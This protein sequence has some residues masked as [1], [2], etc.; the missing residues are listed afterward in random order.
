MG[1]SN[2]RIVLKSPLYGG[3][4]G[5]VC[6]AMANMGICDLAIAEPRPL[7][8]DEA[9][10]MACHARDILDRRTEFASLA[11]AVA[12]CGLVMVTTA[13]LGLYRQHARTPRGWADKALEGSIEGK[14][15]IVFGPEDNGLT[16]EDLAL[17]TQVI[18]I[19]STKEYPSINLAQSVMICCYEMFVTSGMYEPPKEKSGEA[20]SE[21]RER[22]FAMWDQMLMKIGFMKDDKEEHMM[23]G[24][25]RIFSRGSM[26]VDDV[27]ILMGIARQTLWVAGHRVGKGPKPD[28]PAPEA[29]PDKAS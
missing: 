21:L 24:V 27:R 29:G 6:R 26:S 14:V 19:P 1:L 8:L 18:Q 13:R 15:A 3:N 23:L 10:M 16:N 5:S 25:R 12:D 9:R 17:G 20:P 7:D 2:I 4:V 22:M 28:A 11:D